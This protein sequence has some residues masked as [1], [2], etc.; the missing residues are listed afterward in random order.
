MPIHDKEI[1]EL[2]AEQTRLFLENGTESDK[3]A[4]LKKIQKRQ[5]Q[6]M[7]HKDD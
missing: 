2:V 3:V 6:L 5:K 1:N 4:V 7:K